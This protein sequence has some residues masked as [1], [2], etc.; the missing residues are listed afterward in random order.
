[1]SASAYEQEEDEIGEMLADL[2]ERG[3][4]FRLAFEPGTRTPWQVV[5]TDSETGLT[6][7]H[8]SGKTAR[9][10]LDRALEA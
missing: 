3:R 8:F 2:A 10:A 5:A 7:V 6:M 4:Y 9:A 1:M